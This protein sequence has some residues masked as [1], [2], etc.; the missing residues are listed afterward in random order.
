MRLSTD[1]ERDDDA[2]SGVIGTAVAEGIT[3]F[4]TA[5]AYGRDEADLGHNERLLSRA[6]RESGGDRTA[7]IVTKG[8]MSRPG[9]A[10]VP[11]G[12]AGTIRRHCEGSLA[13]L[14][15][16]PIDTYL[17]HAPD[18]RTPWATSVRAL[19]RLVESGLVARVGL[20]N[21]TRDQL[22]QALDLA[23][24]SVVQ[25]GLSVLEDGAVRGGVLARCVER[26]ITVMAHSPLGGLRRVG[27]VL[28]DPT[29]AAVAGRHDG[30]EPAEVALAWLLTL[31]PDLVAIPGARR[32]ETVRSAAR[33][34][35]LALTEADRREL[36]QRFGRRAAPVVAARRD[37]SEREV[38]VVMGIPGSGKTRLA[39]QLA[40][41]G[42]VRL[43]R[44]ERGGTLR[45]I[46]D[47]LDRVLAGGGRKVVLDNTYLTR[48]SRSH[49]IDVARRHGVPVRCQWLDIPPAQAQVNLIGRLLDRFGHL[50]TPAELSAAARREPG[51][52]TPTSQLRTHRELETPTA[53]EGFAVVERVPYSRVPDDAGPAGPVVAV[54][55]SVLDDESWP[56]RIA[57]HTGVPHLLLDWRPGA[58]EAAVPDDLTERAQR[59]ATVVTGPVEIAVCTHP[60]GPP[61]CWC[62][63]PLP[64]LAMAF[65]RRC[66]VPPDRVV[67]I[68]TSAAHRAMAAALAGGSP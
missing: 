25:V 65:A 37:A 13:A 66:G 5:H 49:V 58:E 32:P 48:A 11:D 2:A 17:L 41:D 38:V 44:D 67:V 36:D 27:R 61:R 12:R 40:A 14:T 10:W 55:A 3:V 43:N 46:A 39:R 23:P 33:A 4:D 1:P 50:P 57:A 60:G 31:A 8:G 7:R 68:G 54:A 35:T 45:D 63:P 18:P 16:L 15:P 19:A 20:S 6:L 47:E 26:G 22:D 34:A 64:G 30:H 56:E 24:V 62:R 28:A 59:L 21:V 51:L 29:L 53:D 42:A 52:H 9:G